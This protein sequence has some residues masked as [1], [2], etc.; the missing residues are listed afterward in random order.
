MFKNISGAGFATTF[1]SLLLASSAV[2]AQDKPQSSNQSPDSKITEEVVVTGLRQRLQQA[3]ALANTI[4]KTEVIGVSRIEHKNAVNLSEAIDNS[5]GVRVSNDCSMCGF[6]RIMLNGLRGDQTTILVDGLPT[7]TLI[8]GY[9]AVD[10][11]PTTGVDRIEVARGA[12]ASLIAPEAIGG[13]VNIVTTEAEDNRMLLDLSAG[14]NGYQKVGFLGTAISDD[15]ATRLTLISQFDSRDQFDADNNKVSET[16]FM[17]NKSVIARISHDV[18]ERDNVTFRYANISSDVFGGPVLGERFADGKASSS[19]AVLS[20]YDGAGSDTQDLFV[21]GDVDND[22][23]GKAWETAEWVNTQRNEAS[24]SWLRELNADWNMRLAS[25]WAQHEQ[26]SFYEGFDYFAKDTMLFVDAKFNW[27]ASDAHL[28]TF[29]LDSRTETMRSDSYAGSL[30]ADYV[31]DSFDYDVLGLYLQ[32][33][34]QATDNL[35]I[36]MALRVDQIE[37]DFIDPSKPGTEIN[38]TI[39]SPRVDIRY[40][41]TDRWTSRLSA[42]RGYRAPLSFFETDH[43]ILDSGAGFEV[44]VDKLERSVST[45]YALSFEG[46]QLTST[47]S[48]AYTEVDNL[49]SLEETATAVPVLT[50]LDDSADVATVDLALNY[51]FTDAFNASMII[52]AYDYDDNFKTSYTSA[53]IEQRITLSFDYDIN[54]WEL[55]ANLV[56]FGSRDLGD[57]GYDGYNRVDSSGNV[58]ADS[59]KTLDAPAFFTVDFK[60]Q[61]QLN[62]HLSVY[63]GASNLLD[64]S[65]AGNEESPLMFESDEGA[66]AYDVAYIYGPLR[67]R[68]AYLGVKLEY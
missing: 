51:Q 16:P 31:S 35:D 48:F 6:K 34:W 50:Q 26:D 39:V 27:I 19:G 23:S 33:T 49:A 4:S 53:P 66:G 54:D 2:L 44:D 32:D 3:G 29:G 9:Y 62:E 15:S 61:K 55:V 40:M 25:S 30:S 7:H 12:G 18:T 10:A 64:Y 57:F 17:E 47:L 58:V 5:P 63:A 14:E 67:G 60:V 37:A 59:K 20:R 52:E 65:Q 21:G 43:G 56:W 41:H 42:G 46:E 8:S 28:L 13:T 38:E 24:L 36:A 22:F 1:V 45:T 11:I 68:E